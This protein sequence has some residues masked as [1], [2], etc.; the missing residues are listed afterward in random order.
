MILKKITPY[1]T[2]P[3]KESIDSLKRDGNTMLKNYLIG[4]GIHLQGK[5]NEL[6]VK[7]VTLIPGAIRIQAN[8]KGNVVVKVDELN[9]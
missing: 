7:S 2:Y 3:V 1:L 8:L 4:D 6:T 9:F 5:L